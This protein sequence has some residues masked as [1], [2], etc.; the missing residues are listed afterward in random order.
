MFNDRYG[1]TQAVLSGKKTQTRRIVN[2]EYDEY[3]IWQPNESL[4]FG[5]YGYVEEQGWFFI[6]PK[7][8][9]GEVVAIAQS[10]EDAGYGAPEK[11]LSRLNNTAGWNNK[12]FVRSELMPHRIEITGIRIERLQDISD[13]DC[14][15]EGIEDKKELCCI[16]LF[17]F[18][19]YLKDIWIWGRGPKDV[20]RL[21]ISRIS[22]KSIWNENHFVFVYDFK[23]VK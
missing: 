3:R 6:K 13:E 18:M 12:M 17:G 23:L 10:Y 8:E 4:P 22:G 19:D 2:D 16:T 21:L 7:Y 15:K 1:L 14:I 20:Y 11:I 9:I 5:L